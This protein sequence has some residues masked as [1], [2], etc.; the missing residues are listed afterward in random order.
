[1]P[2]SIVGY[3]RGIGA[4]MNRFAIPTVTSQ[5]AVT[6][7][8][9]VGGAATNASSSPVT[10]TRISPIVMT[11]NAKIFHHAVT[12]SAGFTQSTVSSVTLPASGFTA[13]RSLPVLSFGS[14]TPPDVSAAGSEIASAG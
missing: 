14:R 9:I 3:S 1:M 8:F 2:G 13:A 4:L 12:R 5:Q 7:L 6:K 10:D 11:K